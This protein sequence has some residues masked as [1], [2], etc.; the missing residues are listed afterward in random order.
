MRHFPMHDAFI[1]NTSKDVYN[2]LYHPI[3][4]ETSPSVYRR[5]DLQWSRTHTIAR[6]ASA[7]SEDAHKL[8]EPSDFRQQPLFLLPPQLEGLQLFSG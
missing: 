5:P 3:Y 7:V 2:E 4:F 1:D 6:P 8:I